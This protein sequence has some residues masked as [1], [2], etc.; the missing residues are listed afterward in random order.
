MELQ[1][2]LDENSTLYQRAL[3]LY[4]SAFP[5][6]ERRDKDELTR[7]FNNKNFHFDIILDGEFFVGIMF[8]WERDNY[9][10]LEHFAVLEGL[11]NKGFGARA[12]EL[13]KQKNKKIIL[14]IEPPLS[15]LTQ[16]RYAF[17]TR[18][19]FIMNPYYHIQAKYHIGDEDLELKIL[20][21]PRILDEREY[22][23]FYKY[24]IREMSVKTTR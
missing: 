4:E 7:V 5:F 10:F 22:T 20:S 14:E 2:I 9:I 15:N 21:Y 6:L 18:N 12:L 13:L 1:R 16:R 8:Y 23:D 11:R 3:N 17:Y 19:G 24:M